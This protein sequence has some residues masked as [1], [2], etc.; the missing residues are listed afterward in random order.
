MAITTAADYKTSRG[1]AGTDFDTRIAEGVA[2]AER[3]VR[4]YCNRDPDDGFESGE[5]TETYAGDGTARI[6]LREWPVTAVASVKFREGAASGA[7]TFGD[8]LEGSSY[9]VSG[10]AKSIVLDSIGSGSVAWGEFSGGLRWPEGID[11]V[12]VVYTGGY[13]AGN[14]PTTLVDAVFSLVDVWLDDSGSNTITLASRA[15]GIENQVA[16][17]PDIVAGRLALMLAP[18]VRG[19]A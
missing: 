9:F 11:A 1:I 6:R 17:L 5:R 13:T 3:F 8:A 12:Q 15:I 4:E 7:A 2:W 18:F 14:F 16:A 19:I 10:D